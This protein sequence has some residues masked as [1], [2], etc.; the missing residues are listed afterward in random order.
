MSARILVACVGN[1]F[2]GDDG[3]GVEVARVLSRAQLPAGV[4]L[5][6]VGIRGLH[7][8]YE[9]LDPPGLLVVVDALPRGGVPGTVYVLE[10]DL[11]E[12]LPGGADAHSVDLPSVFAMV[13]A[14]GG[15][16]PRVLVVGCEPEDV[17]EGMGLSLPVEQAVAGAVALVEEILQRESTQVERGAAPGAARELE[18]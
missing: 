2:F 1:V 17:R 18:S 11:D 8:A 3:F 6:D 7:L 15:A 5:R 10:P 13:R 16:L 14:M 9:L 4:V 12:V